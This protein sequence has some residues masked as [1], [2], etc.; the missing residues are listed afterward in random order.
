MYSVIIDQE[1]NVTE[2]VVNDISQNSGEE[3]EKANDP[4][5]TVMNDPNKTYLFRLDIEHK[6]RKGQ[7]Y[8]DLIHRGSKNNSINA[9]FTIQGS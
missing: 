5:M 4:T 6:G 8:L 9:T 2:S 1:G 7:I 3:I